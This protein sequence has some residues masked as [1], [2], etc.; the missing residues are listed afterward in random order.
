MLIDTHAH[1]WWDCYAR[2]LNQVIERAKSVGIEKII[3]PGTDVKSSI[4]AIE[5]ARSYEG[6]ILAAVG[7]HPEELLNPNYNYKTEEL[8]KL[9]E[10]NLNY[11]VAVG[12]VGIDLYTE[13]IKA[14]IDRQKALF[15]QMCEL[16]KVIKL[17][18]IIHTRES[19]KEV[20]EILREYPNVQA[21][22]HCFGGT[23]EEAK[24]ILKQGYYMSFCGNVSWSKR[25]RRI[26]NIVPI[27]RL[28]SETDS[29]FMTPVNEWG[30]KIGEQNEPANV[31]ISLQIIARERN[32][33]I[34][35]IEKAIEKNVR[36]LFN[37]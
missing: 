9:I 25:V 37:I 28:L 29:P 14:T 12:E 16:A 24:D 2:N 4:K 36:R 13:E 7:I 10:N 31:K 35:E 18:M 8:K 6:L 34:E 33:T 27:E 17:P 20:L 1:L 5:L 15:R 21:Q 26:S 23:E 3:V 32:M 19:V 22:F 30:E 11:V